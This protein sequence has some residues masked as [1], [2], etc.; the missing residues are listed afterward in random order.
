MIAVLTYSPFKCLLEGFLKWKDPI[1][2]PVPP[3]RRQ[4]THFPRWRMSDKKVIQVC[5]AQRMLCLLLN[6]C[7]FESMT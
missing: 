1:R 2:C 6:P 5:V 3:R 7:V 4:A